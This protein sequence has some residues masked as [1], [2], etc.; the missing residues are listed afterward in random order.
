MEV[1]DRQ[2]IKMLLERVEMLEKQV[3]GLLA[4]T[5]RA[6]SVTQEIQATLDDAMKI[7]REMLMQ[8]VAMTATTTK[9]A[10]NGGIDSKPE[11]ERQGHGKR[12][13]GCWSCD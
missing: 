9:A 12:Y 13:L 6:I 4:V 2:Q 7:N 3:D 1:Y 11:K 8:L 5:K 10:D